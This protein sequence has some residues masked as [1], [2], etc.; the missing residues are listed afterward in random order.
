MSSLQ[1]LQDKSSQSAFDKKVLG[2]IQHLHPYVKHRLYV[3]ES[4]GIIPKNM[5]HSNGMIDEAIA[6]LYENGIN[7]DAEAL[8]VKL[9]LFEI[10]DDLLDELL[11]KE[12]FHTQTMS[13]NSILQEELDSLDEVFTVDAGNDYIMQDEL[14]DI[15]YQNE[16]RHKHIFLYDNHESS[17]IKALELE[18][19]SIRDTNKL[20]SKFYSWAPKRAADII[21]LY[22][23]GKLDHAEIAR[24]KKIDIEGV[25]K[26]IKKVR[27]GFRVQLD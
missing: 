5:Y 21:D 18:D 3:A 14:T 15:S 10:V 9:K 1:K 22:V 25:Q 24:V 16:D 13:T 20:L 26:I 23:F 11:K 8:A 27:Q 19:I 2:A 7:V 12:A 17:I 4:K 6:V